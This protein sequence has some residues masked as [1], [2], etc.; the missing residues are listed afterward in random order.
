MPE[1]KVYD[2]KI[3]DETHRISDQRGNGQLRREVWVA[4]ESGKRGVLKKTPGKITRYNLAY[5]NYGLHSGDNGRVVG[6]DNLHG[7]HHRH[8]FGN[9]SSVDFVTFEA[10]EDRFE[11]DWMALRRPPG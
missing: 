3:I 8:Y 9:V 7:Y 1:S 4:G 6:Y 2:T 10:I 11:S 5:I